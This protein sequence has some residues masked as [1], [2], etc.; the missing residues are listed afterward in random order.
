MSKNVEQ[1]QFQRPIGSSG[2]AV[3]LSR[4]VGKS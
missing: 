2:G 3:R 1:G 4:R